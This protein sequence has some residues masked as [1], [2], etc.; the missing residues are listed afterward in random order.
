MSD[1]QVTDPLSGLDPIPAHDHL[2]T[3]GK[4]IGGVSAPHSASSPPLSRKQRIYL[5]LDYAGETNIHPVNALVY[6]RHA[7]RMLADEVY[8]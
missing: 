5:M 8:R 7:I 1:K 4:E 2:D 3:G 6:L